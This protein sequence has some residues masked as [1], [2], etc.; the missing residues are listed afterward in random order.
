MHGTENIR[1]EAIRNLVTGLTVFYRTPPQQLE[2]VIDVL[3][4]APESSLPLPVFRAEITIP[5]EISADEYSRDGKSKLLSRLI[6]ELAEWYRVSDILA[7]E[8][9]ATENPP[10]TTAAVTTAASPTPSHTPVNPQAIYFLQLLIEHS[11]EQTRT[12]IMRF[13]NTQ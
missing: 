8:K 11:A 1:L 13:K 4:T 5:G 7:L 10:T 6:D 9:P 2:F 12:L 3:K